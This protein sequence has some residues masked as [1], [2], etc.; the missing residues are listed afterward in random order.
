MWVRRSR[1]N[2]TRA[3]NSTSRVQG[4][5]ISG[6]LAGTMCPASRPGLGPGLVRA[7]G[8]R[9]RL[10]WA[11]GPWCSRVGKVKMALVCDY[12]TRV[13]SLGRLFCNCCSKSIEWPGV[14]DLATGALLQSVFF[15]SPVHLSFF[16][17]PLFCFRISHT[18]SFPFPSPSDSRMFIRSLMLSTL[19]VAAS[20]RS[21][22]IPL[23]FF[24]FISLLLV[25]FPGRLS[26]IFDLCFLAGYLLVFLPYV[27][28]FF[29]QCNFGGF[30]SG[31]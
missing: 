24:S 7:L 2:S 8:L 20:S 4:S 9:R 28:V 26:S 12:V 17:P 13:L 31:P 22:P 29:Q 11:G 1:S 16:V 5:E 10:H 14:R 19:V 23:I 25:C 15:P 21:F 3:N 18:R 27:R 6:R 30:Y